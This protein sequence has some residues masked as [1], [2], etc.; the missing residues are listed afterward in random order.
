MGIKRLS[1]NIVFVVGCILYLV[2]SC[3]SCKGREVQPFF[4]CS[5]R[6][7]NCYGLCSHV[8]NRG[9][10]DFQLRNEEFSIMNNLGVGI[11]RTDIYWWKF[12]KDYSASHPDY[13]SVFISARNHSIRTLGI[14]ESR[15]SI[16]QNAWDDLGEYGRYVD[17]LLTNYGKDI[18]YWEV[19]NE[20][21]R[22]KTISQDSLAAVY[23]QILQ[24]C[25]KKIKQYNKH[26]QVVL[27]SITNPQCALLDDLCKEGCAK[28][29]DAFNVHIYDAPENYFKKFERLKHVFDKYHIRP[30]LWLTE[31]GIHTAFDKKNKYVFSED[32]QA[33]R[34][35]RIH[36]IAFS[37]GIDKVFVYNLKST[38]R[39]KFNPEEHFGILHPDLS[40][41]PAYHTY[42]QLIKMLP[43]GSTRPLIRIE[44]NIY[45]CEWGRPD[46]IRVYAIWKTGR[47]KQVALSIS[48]RYT[49]EDQ[50][51]RKLPIATTINVSNEVKYIIGANNVII[52]YMLL[53]GN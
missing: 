9:R 36:L 40:S 52:N 38:E 20:I 32:E 21:D 7:H 34:I 46:K 48:G 49:I 53:I 18:E 45:I 6:I 39:D 10:N 1:S 5:K 19:I 14:L 25:Y 3:Q 47:E 12:P 51:G 41:K 13:D 27:G 17:Y 37:L 4:S 35:P 33:R 43:E 8:T 2:C 30:K 15:K 16:S 24:L 44:D 11:V 29:C 50:Y 23:P 26:H 31:C 22:I 42:R 28:Y